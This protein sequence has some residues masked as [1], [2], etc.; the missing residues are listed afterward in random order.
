MKWLLNCR[1]ISQL[2]DI[3]HW[4]KSALPALPNMEEEEEGGGLAGMLRFTTFRNGGVNG[5]GKMDGGTQ[6]AS[7]ASKRIV[8]KRTQV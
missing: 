1:M 7:A 4:Y 2:L 8:K 5:V 6:T 3:V